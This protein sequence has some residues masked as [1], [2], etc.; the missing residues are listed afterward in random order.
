MKNYFQLGT[1]LSLL[2]FVGCAVAQPTSVIRGDAYAPRVEFG[3]RLE[4]GNRI[5]HG[6]GQDAKA[7]TDYAKNFDGDHQP[8]IYM[9]YIGLCKPVAT[10]SEW[11][12]AV[13]GEL[14]ARN[15]AQPIPQIG[16]NL[17]GGKDNGSALDAEVAGGKYDEQIKAFG[18][19]V[20]D[21]KRPVFIRIGYEFDGNWNNYRPATF[22]KAWQRVTTKLR[23]RGIPFATVWCAAGASAGW[24]TMSK[25]LEFY[26]G[27]ESVDWW[28]VD[29]FSEDEFSKPQLAT[30][31][32]AARIHRKP[33]MIGEMTPRHVGVLEGQKSWDRWFGPMIDLL[34]RRPE[35]KATAYIN[36]EWREWSDRL[37]FP[38]H[39]WGDARIERNSVVRDRWVQE[40]SHPV[41]LH[42]ARDGSNSLPPISTASS[43][44]PSLKTV[45]KDHFLVGAA[46][47][48]TQ[49]TGQNDAQVALIKSQFN[50]ITPENV[51]KW[52]AVHP[53][54][55]KFNFAPSDHYVEFGEKNGMF[56]IGHTLV[57]HGQT[58]KWVF[59]DNHGQPTDRNTLLA[60]M[61]NHIHTVVG[62]YKGRIKGWDVVNEALNED[63]TLRQT[64]WLKIIGEDY[65]VK[66]FEF[67][68]AADPTAELY[69][70]DYSLE[71]LDKRNGAIALVKKLQAAGVKITGIGTQTHAKMDWPT[72]QLVDD[73]LT[74]F[75]KLG[76]KVMITELD[77]DLLPAASQDNGADVNLRAAQNPTLNP[78]AKGLPDPMQ[79]ALAKRYAEL[80]AVYVRHSKIVDRVTFWGVTDGDSWLNG[81][82]V[83]GRTSYP[84]LFDRNCQPKPAFDGVIQEIKPRNLN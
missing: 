42:A 74:A 72:P 80:F 58:P 36:W 32:D 57:W 26:P 75:G 38:W 47:N 44:S 39:D 12:E 23:A 30:F 33:V 61:S 50:T 29:I 49:F 67:T 68:H 25:L 46:L 59:E 45:F 63:G 53:D 81:W 28:G 77:I 9:T 14:A 15:P 27:D 60:R 3:A 13:R 70:N 34:K 4:P 54:A 1:V 55:D 66:A 21:L 37:G 64:P 76:L 22:Q 79:K 40:L 78:Y 83:S 24:P 73:T 5:I 7:F 82:P 71:N 8:L 41:Y 65:L 31:L 69:Y 2:A 11:G 18:D 43:T 17:T 16:L 62:R 48:E 56:I 6:A 10:I 84:L 19:A 35:I 52:E 51:L 20:A